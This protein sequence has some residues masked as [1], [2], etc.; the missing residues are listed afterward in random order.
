M[1][2]DRFVIAFDVDGT[3]K[4][5]DPE[6]PIGLERVKQLKEEGFT[7]GIIGAKDKVE[8]LLPG[9]DFYYQGDA[10]KFVYLKEV[11]E[12]FNSIMG[13]YVADM[14]SDRKAALEA[15]FCFIYANDFR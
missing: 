15:G 10:V 9:L 7:V 11:K 5:G 12:R 14:E 8:K 1:Q 13:I 4:Y 6:G 3:L 2:K